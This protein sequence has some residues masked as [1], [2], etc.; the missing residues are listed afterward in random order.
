VLVPGA[1]ISRP[2]HASHYNSPLEELLDVWFYNTPYEQSIWDGLYIGV[3]GGVSLVPTVMATEF[4]PDGK[5]RFAWGS[6]T[7]SYFGAQAGLQRGNWRFEG[8]YTWSVNPAA[9]TMPLPPNVKIG[10]DTETHGFFGNGIYTPRFVFGLPVTPHIGVGVGALN[11]TTTIKVNDTK[12]S[13]SSNWAPGAQAI[14]GL[15]W[16]ISPR[17]SLDLDYRYQTSLGDVEYKSLANGNNPRNKVTSPYH[18]S[19]VTL[20]LNLHF[21]AAVPP[22]G[23]RPPGFVPQSVNPTPPPRSELPQAR[24][25]A[26]LVP[27]N[28]AVAVT[29]ATAATAQRF[30]LRYD[31][32]N[33]VLTPSSVRTLHDAIDA[34]EAGQDVRIAI[35]G[36]EADADY[37]DGSPCARRALRL[38]HLLARYGVENPGHLLAGG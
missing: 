3:D 24:Q 17:L 13:D 20:G 8:Q 36:C 28:T 1:P 10:G 9:A 11:V 30:T 16:Q 26:S 19:Y 4:F 23:T 12:V 35:A 14:G 2:Y 34:I 18:S 29:R 7:G 22:G 15:T 32:A 38:R 5:D 25:V 21:P 31:E 33:A 27:V 37:A 6:S